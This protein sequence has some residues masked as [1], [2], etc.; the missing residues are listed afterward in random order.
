MK[1]NNYINLLIIA[2]INVFIVILIVFLSRISYYIDGLS[3][4]SFVDPI[5]Y[6]PRYI[7]LFMT[8]FFIFEIFVIQKIINKKD[9]H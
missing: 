9:M 6:I 8:I 2:N 1:K 5:N 3:S 4:N 7:F